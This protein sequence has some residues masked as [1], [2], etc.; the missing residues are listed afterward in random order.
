MTTRSKRAKTAPVSFKAAAARRRQAEPQPAVAGFEK[1]MPFADWCK[2]KS[3]SL[4]TGKRLRAAG[5][6]RVV[7]LSASRVGVTESADAE[8]MKACETA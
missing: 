2:Q 7:R 8:F 1:V 6:I 5:K 4:D 3:I